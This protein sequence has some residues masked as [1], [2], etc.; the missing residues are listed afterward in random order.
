MQRAK[1]AVDVASGLKFLHEQQPPIICGRIRASN[2]PLFDDDVAKIGG[3]K[4]L[5]RTPTSLGAHA[6]AGAPR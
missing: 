3:I 5:Q 2:I 4:P 1:I 6:L